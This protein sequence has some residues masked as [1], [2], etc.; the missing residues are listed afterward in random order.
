[1]TYDVVLN[2]KPRK[3][4]TYS[5]SIDERIDFIGI[6]LKSIQLQRYGPSAML[7]HVPILRL[8]SL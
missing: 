1:M 6:F 3:A 2:P 8:L 5:Q 7:G 4:I